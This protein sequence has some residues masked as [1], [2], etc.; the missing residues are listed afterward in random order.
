MRRPL[1]TAILASA[2]ACARPASADVTIFQ[3]PVIGGVKLDLYG[4]AQPRFSWQES[5]DRPTVDLH[6]NAAFT[7]LRAR[8][9]AIASIGRWGRAQFEIELAREV[10]QPF[11]AFVVLTPIS[12]RPATLN[13]QVGQFRVPFSRQNLVNSLSHQLSDVAYFV[14]PSM[15]VDRDIGAMLWTD[16]FDGRARLKVGVWNGNEPGRGQ[17]QNLDPHFLAAAR[18]E[19]SPLG[20]APNFEGDLRP[21]HA[22]KKPIVT[23]G[24]GVMRNRLE[25]KHFQRKY[26]GADVGAWYRGASLYGELYYHVDDPIS[27]VGATATARVKQ[28]GWNVQA[29]YFLPLPWVR[30]H[31]EIV[32]RVEYLDPNIDVKTPVNDNGARDL[33]QSN[34]TWGFMGFFVGANYF[35]NHSHTLKGQV[36][37]E[38]R[39]ET[40][41]C[42][43]GQTGAGC[44]GYI[45]NNMFVAQV[46][47][48]F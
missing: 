44:T 6:P 9:G 39:N 42:L 17:T 14:R 10:G 25:D 36:H 15:I 43:E 1:A 24:F 32:G 8:I 30:E 18:L 41:R 48:G 3:T 2:L 31:L 23:V 7:I 20:A 5:D 33:D 35:F 34:P 22:Q 46:T 11:D 12:T 37:Y 47:A 45:K 40:K 4:W 38:I 13:L 21:L 26:L 28:L 19:I 27:T 29:G 16:H